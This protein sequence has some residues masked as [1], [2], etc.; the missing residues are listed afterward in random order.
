M[1]ELELAH[2][3]RRLLIE[4]KNGVEHGR[5]PDPDLLDVEFG[6]VDNE[7]AYFFVN[8]R[9]RV[10]PTDSDGKAKLRITNTL[11]VLVESFGPPMEPFQTSGA[12]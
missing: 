2:K 9:G 6:E 5:V 1:N 3:I 7:T 10:G 12:R 11:G 8:E 4:A